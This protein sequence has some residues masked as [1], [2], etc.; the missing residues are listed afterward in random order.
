MTF[1]RAF[2]EPPAWGLFSIP[3]KICLSQQ[4]FS[5]YFWY[6]SYL[7][8]SYQ[9]VRPRIDFLQNMADMGKVFFITFRPSQLRVLGIA[10]CILFNCTW[11]VAWMCSLR[12]IIIAVLYLYGIFPLLLLSLLLVSVL[13]T[14]SS[15]NSAIPPQSSSLVSDVSS[16][17]TFSFHFPYWLIIWYV[18]FCYIYLSLPK[19][20]D[21]MYHVPSGA[22]LVV[23]FDF[24]ITSS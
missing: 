7:I 20:N 11:R 4:Y 3:E 9:I 24:G 15:S 19:Y 23:W 2:L 5:E 18:I 12:H 21:I 16:L 22:F 14:S 1:S 6:L 13:T 17:L 10:L 8:Y